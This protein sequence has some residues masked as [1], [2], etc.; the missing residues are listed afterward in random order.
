MSTMEL[1]SAGT[2]MGIIDV[3][4]GPDHLSA[5]ATLS[6]T[7][8]SSRSSHP[9]AFLLGVKWG[10]GHS[11]GLLVVAGILIAV[12]ESSSETI[13][14]DDMWSM[15]LEGFVGVFMLALGSYGL[16]KAFRNREDG[17]SLSSSIESLKLKEGDA[18]EDRK[19]KV[20]VERPLKMII[21]RSLRS[22]N[23][24][25]RMMEEVLDRDSK[26]GA[27]SPRSNSDKSNEE[28]EE[29]DDHQF[30]STLT[31]SASGLS[32]SFVKYKANKPPL[33]RATS[34]VREHAVPDKSIVLDSS[35]RPNGSYYFPGILAL[36]AGVVHGVAGPGGVLGVIPAVQLRDPKSATIYLSMFCLTSTLVMGFF[37][38]FYGTFSQWLAGGQRGSSG[39]RVFLVEVGS[40][41]LS[42]AVGIIWLV[43]L[44]I[45]KLEEVFP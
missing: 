15:I 19:I 17:V 32:E 4:T 20:G 34:L 29:D 2:L 43:L 13:G 23:C 37:A 33:M 8:I 6:G 35:N 10:I 44:S 16:H 27:E 40:A 41:F 11:L 22:G 42:I 5:L 38:A 24:I 26:Y 12:E 14:M 45:R 25:T 18:S 3:L 36:V 31:T 21:D 30:L 1:I 28:D 39:S 7:N 9:G